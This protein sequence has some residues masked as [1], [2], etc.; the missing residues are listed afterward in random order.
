MVTQGERINKMT[1]LIQS[2]CR[3]LKAAY[4]S[5]YRSY[6]PAPIFDRIIK[7]DKKHAGEP[8]DYECELSFGEPYPLSPL[9]V[10]R[11][12]DMGEAARKMPGRL[13]LDAIASAAMYSQQSQDDPV[14][15]QKLVGLWTKSVSTWT[16]NKNIK[17]RIEEGDLVLK[18]SMSIAI[19]IVNVVSTPIVQ[20]RL[21]GDH[22]QDVTAAIRLLN[23]IQGKVPIIMGPPWTEPA[24]RKTLGDETQYYGWLVT[25]YL[26]LNRRY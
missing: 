6:K 8:K 12:R 18:F 2:A 15:P 7:R 17:C 11:A 24:L 13:L 21:A 14:T 1:D 19:G 22:T 16:S 20:N 4:D 25:A 5:G 23:Q 3:Q 10:A 26:S 9:I